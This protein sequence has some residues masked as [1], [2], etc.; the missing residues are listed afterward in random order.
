M[1]LYAGVGSSA[2]PRLE[3]SETTDALGEEFNDGQQR[4]VTDELE[5]GSTFDVTCKTRRRQNQAYHVSKET[6]KTTAHFQDPRPCD[7][8]HYGRVSKVRD[9]ASLRYQNGAK[10]SYGMRRSA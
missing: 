7:R 6:T 1:D 8:G 10:Q 3:G 9:G 4:R 5:C 2:A